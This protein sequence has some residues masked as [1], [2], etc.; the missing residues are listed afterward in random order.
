M[1][2][3]LMWGQQTQGQ[4]Q[5]SPR[6]CPGRLYNETPHFDAV[7]TQANRESSDVTV[8]CKL[9]QPEGTSP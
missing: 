5:K 9:Q 1:I 4:E 2:P 7:T 8:D 6:L 3:V